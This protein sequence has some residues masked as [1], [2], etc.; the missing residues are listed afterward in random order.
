[1]FCLLFSLSA[2]DSNSVGQQLKVLGGS[3]IWEFPNIDNMVKS[4]RDHGVAAFPPP[5]MP[6][7]DSNYRTIT[8]ADVFGSSSPVLSLPATK[9]MATQEPASGQLR[10]TTLPPVGADMNTNL[11]NTL[12]PQKSHWQASVCLVLCLPWSSNHI[13]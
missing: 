13:I 12:Q 11:L 7:K 10:S 1:L 3:R 5:S 6:L 8:P 2:L 4:H 9:M